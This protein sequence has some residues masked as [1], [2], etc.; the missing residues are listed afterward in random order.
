M[1]HSGVADYTTVDEVACSFIGDSSTPKATSSTSNKSS[2]QPIAASGHRATYAD[3]LRKLPPPRSISQTN[4]H[5]AN[6]VIGKGHSITL[7][8]A[9]PRS[10]TQG[11]AN[12]WGSNGDGVRGTITGVFITR[13]SP[14]TTAAMLAT[15]I[16]KETKLTVRPEKLITKF[17]SYSSFYIRGNQRCRDELLNCELWPRGVLLKP[18]YEK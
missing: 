6:T 14:S 16:R 15:H 5:N 18:F 12:Q 17:S 7:K 1:D 9:Q 11:R 10:S 13:L 4:K 8:A 3:Q 2:E